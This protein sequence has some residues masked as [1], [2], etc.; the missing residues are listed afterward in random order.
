MTPRKDWRDTMQPWEVDF[1]TREIDRFVLANELYCVDNYR[2]ARMWV[3]SQMRRFRKQADDGCCGSAE[4][5]VK[6]FNPSKLRWDL[7]IVGCNYGH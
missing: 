1:C 5:V 2:A 6:R 3:S 7:Y 4:W